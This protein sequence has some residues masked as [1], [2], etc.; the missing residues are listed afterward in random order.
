MPLRDRLPSILP[1][2]REDSN[3]GA[4][5]SAIQSEF[6]RFQSDTD[7]VQDSLF[8]P[9]ATGQALDLIGAE[10]GLIGQ[11]AGRSDA[12][13]QEFLQGV[14]PVF[15]GRGTEKDVEIAVAAGVANSP[16]D[17]DLDQDF[18]NREYRVELL[19]WEP[20]RS[21]TT[22]ELADLAD[23]PTVDRVDPVQL[24]SEPNTVTVALKDTKVGIETISAPI[25][26]LVSGDDALS[27]LRAAGLSAEKLEPLSTSGFRL[28]EQTI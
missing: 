17:V 19:D 11:R 21:S 7:A 1:L 2:L 22:R 9:T 18:Q 20:H 27:E 10:F 13:Y 4:V 16:A 26:V 15:N 23:P 28:S 3:I 6:S 14:V 5:I 25:A 24:L 12:A 8:I